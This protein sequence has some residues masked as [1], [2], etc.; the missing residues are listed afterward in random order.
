MISL[1]LTIRRIKRSKT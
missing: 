1:K